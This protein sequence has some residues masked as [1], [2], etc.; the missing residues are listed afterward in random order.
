MG[1]IKFGIWECQNFGNIM[2]LSPDKIIPILTNSQQIIGAEVAPESVVQNKDIAELQKQ[3]INSAG[4]IGF[5]TETPLIIHCKD[6][7]AGGCTSLQRILTST[8][9]SPAFNAYPAEDVFS[10]SLTRSEKF[11]SQFQD[12]DRV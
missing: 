10:E 11:L 2:K 4:K 7:I 9:W 6:N 12:M 8:G 5:E 3:L 1:L